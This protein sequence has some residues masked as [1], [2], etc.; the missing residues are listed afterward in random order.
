MSISTVICNYPCK[1]VLNALGMIQVELGYEL[2]KAR[3]LLS[4]AVA[5]RIA[6]S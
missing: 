6:A 3:P 1:S 4:M 2:Q 5:V